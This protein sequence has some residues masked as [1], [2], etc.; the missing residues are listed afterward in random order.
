M[1]LS[2]WRKKERD[3]EGEQERDW[4]REKGNLER[5]Q[6]VV[7]ACHSRCSSTLHLSSVD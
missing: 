1:E 3:R 4:E 5:E 7:S 2:I 6:S